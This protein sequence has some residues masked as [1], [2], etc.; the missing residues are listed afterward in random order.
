MNS[1]LFITLARLGFYSREQIK[2]TAEGFQKEEE[3]QQIFT[4]LTENYIEDFEDYGLEFS[5]NGFDCS[6]MSRYLV[7]ALSN[8]TLEIKV[9]YNLFYRLIE[10]FGNDKDKMLDLADLIL[11]GVANDLI[12]AIDGCRLIASLWSLAGYLPELAE[13]AGREQ[14]IAEFD[15]I[16]NDE[17][18]DIDSRLEAR[19]SKAKIKN[20]IVIEAQHYIKSRV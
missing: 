1:T 13:F 7:Q 8:K 11:F 3:Y 18:I 12:D 14:D 5:Q 10:I 9:A 15:N 16:L 17:S 4:I 19:L 6:S 2:S 20:S